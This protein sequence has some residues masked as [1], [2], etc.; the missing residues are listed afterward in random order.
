MYAIPRYYTEEL[1]QDLDCD[2]KIDLILQQ[3]HD[4]VAFEDHDTSK[5][6]G[7]TILKLNYSAA[8]IKHMACASNCTFL[9][10]DSP[11][12]SGATDDK[13]NPPK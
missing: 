7:H 13:V 1:R 2:R 6:K 11:S 3:S 4:M 12:G 10:L 9:A 5:S 8:N